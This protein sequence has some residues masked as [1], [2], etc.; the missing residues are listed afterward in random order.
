MRHVIDLPTPPVPLC[1]FCYLPGVHWSYPARPFEVAAVPGA[2]LAGV[3]FT[4]A[5]A[6]CDACHGLIGA[7]D[8]AGLAVR[9]AEI[10]AE[11]GEGPPVPFEDLVVVFR[12]MQ[13]L[14]FSHQDGLPA[15]AV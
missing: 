3:I 6:C 7:G 9:A 1:D 13:G 12:Q 2:G 4:D 14:F 15:A 10:M 8:R 11:S 5:W